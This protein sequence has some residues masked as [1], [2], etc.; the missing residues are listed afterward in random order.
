MAKSAPKKPAS[1][2]PAAKKPAAKKS[3]RSEVLHLE[4]PEGLALAALLQP[5]KAAA[6]RKALL[7]ALAP[8]LSGSRPPAWLVFSGGDVLEMI[9]HLGTPLFWATGAD[10][11]AFFSEHEGDQLVLR[12]GGKGL[13][14]TGDADEDVTLTARDAA[15]VTAYEDGVV[16]KDLCW[17]EAAPATLA[18]LRSFF[19]EAMSA[20]TG[21]LPAYEEA[22]APP[23]PPVSAADGRSGAFLG[24]PSRAG[25]APQGPRAAPTLRWSLTYESNG[26]AEWGGSPVLAGDLVFAGDSGFAASVSA[27][28]TDGT[29]AWKANL[30]SS[31]SWLLGNACVDR[32]VLY[33]G[34]NKGLFALDARTGK[35]RWV[36]KQ[37][38]IQGS[39]L[40]VGDRCYVGTGDGVVGLS[41]ETGRRQ[42]K[43]EVK[44]DKYKQGVQG[45]L[46]YRD[47]CFYFVAG[48]RLQAVTLEGKLKWKCPAYQRGA[49]SLDEASVYTWAPDGLTAVD[50]ATGQVR[51]AH[52]KEGLD[53]EKTIAVGADRVVARVDGQLV[54]LDKASGQVLWRT[55]HER[56]DAIGSASPVIAGDVV[57]SFSM[58]AGIK[59]V[60]GLDLATGKAL[61]SHTDFPLRANEKAELSWYWTPAVGPD[62]TLYVQ[63]YGLHALR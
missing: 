47:G 23:P 33:Q 35:Q 10:D 44:R 15:K 48:D 3:H 61:W 36:S 42:W 54:A 51:W 60:V 29:L 62:G 26:G 56:P 34:T 6:T 25:T 52:R 14:L 58:S 45:G 16:L 4:G 5:K 38:A 22:L 13:R 17:A 9:V 40:V 19:A 2:K 31:Q 32:G 50:Q 39:P 12:A 1:K 57:V 24:G 59:S 8:R 27:T 43:Y 7:A 63:A 20:Y 30:T 49:P 21:G 37:S 11:D 55:A 41:L 18:G 53:W 28:R 46:S